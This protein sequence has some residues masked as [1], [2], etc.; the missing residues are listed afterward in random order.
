M[1]LAEQRRAIRLLLNER[2]PADAMAAYYAFHHAEERTQL[3]ITP[4]DAGPGQATGFVTLS[5]TGIDLFRPLVTMRLPGESRDYQSSVRL[6]ER[7]LQPGMPVILSAPVA[8]LPLLH[9]LLDVQSEEMLRL[10]ALDRGRYEPVINV[11][12][13]R[14]TAPNALPRY[15][16][17]SN[18]SA[19]GEV[20]ASAGLNWQSPSFAEIAVFTRPDQR[21]QGWGRSVVAAIVQELLDSGRVPLYVVAEDNQPSIQLAESVGF[22]DT[23]VR[24]T[25]LQ[26]S[27]KP[28]YQ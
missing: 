9:V 5:R 25:M 26:A 28:E 22:V 8:Y 3:V 11:L 14:T 4:E 19:S 6:L 2:D 15:I 12:V 16:I 24:E 27:R 13:A 18:Q 21:R 7:A 1:T 23:G 20:V 10:Y 17:R